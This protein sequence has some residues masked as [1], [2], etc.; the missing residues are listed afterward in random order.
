[1]TTATCRTLAAIVL[2]LALSSGAAATASAATPAALPAHVIGE[3]CT[4][5]E[6][7]MHAVAPNG[8]P[9]ICEDYQ[10]VPA[11]GGVARPPRADQQPR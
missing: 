3:Q 9:I 4:G 10:W 6:I 11:H 2:G 1:M 5:A 8:V 7:G